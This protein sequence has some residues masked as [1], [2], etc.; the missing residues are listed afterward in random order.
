MNKS[1]YVTLEELLAKR[2]GDT[3]RIAKA[4]DEILTESR[5]HRLAD[6]RKAKHLT[7]EQL[8]ERIDIDQ[9]RVSRIENGDLSRTEVGTLVAYAQAVGGT[10]ELVVRIGDVAIPL[11]TPT[12]KAPT[13]ANSAKRKSASTPGTKPNPRKATVHKTRSPRTRIA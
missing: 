2:P 7:Q 1:S 5:A 11:T 10:L 3:A 13:R 6:V 4:R 8:A 9:S 12:N